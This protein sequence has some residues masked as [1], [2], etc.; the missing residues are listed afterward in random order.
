MP[1]VRTIRAFVGET[2]EVQWQRKVPRPDGLQWPI[3]Y[4]TLT[5]RYMAPP[6]AAWA[7]RR[8]DEST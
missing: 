2:I 7:E 6:D 1:M 3:D 4:E 8:K 5:E